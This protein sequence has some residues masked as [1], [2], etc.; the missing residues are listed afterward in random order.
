MA[1]SLNELAR[2]LKTLII[3]LQSDPHNQSNLRADRYN[4]LKLL[5]NPNSNHNPHVVVDLAMSDA[6]FDIKTGQKLKGGLGLYER[7]VLICFNKSGTLSDLQD[8]WVEIIKNGG[9]EKD[10]K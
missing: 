5:M 9:K 1:K 10:E 3:E 6:E 4:N 7:Y 2:E 8:T